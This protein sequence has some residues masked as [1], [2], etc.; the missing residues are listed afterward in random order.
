MIAIRGT[1]GK[2]LVE[3]QD[4]PTFSKMRL[5]SWLR[6]YSTELETLIPPFSAKSGTLP[7]LTIG[8]PNLNRV[9]RR[10]PSGKNG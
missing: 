4:Q 2:R 5:D 9:Q 6:S 7:N 10:N 8:A 3:A 1:I